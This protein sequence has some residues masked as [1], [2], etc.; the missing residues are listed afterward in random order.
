MSHF[1]VL[2]VSS[3]KLDQNV[4]HGLLAP[5]HEFECTGHDDEY[6]QDIDQTEE[7]RTEYETGTERRYQDPEG[8]LHDPYEDRFYRDPTSE[9]AE[10][11]GIGGTGFSNGL[12][13][14]SKN[15]GD[16]KGYRAKVHFIPDDWSE[17]KIPRPQVETFAKF[18][19]DNY[20]RKV[21]A[22][23]EEPDL[24]DE[25]KY[26]YA[27]LD[28][29]G[30][31]VKVINRTN[32][33][34]EWDWWVVGGRWSGFFKLKNITESL[35]RGKLGQPSAFG[36][37]RDDLDGRAD[38]CQIRDIDLDGMRSEAA[39]TALEEFD[40]AHAVIAG[41]ELPDFEALRAEC[42]DD[43]E[44]FREKFW[45]HPV[46]VELNAIKPFWNADEVTGLRRTREQV[47]AEARAG[48][49]STFAVLKDGKWHERGS[50][51]WFGMVSDEKDYGKWAS[52][53]N[54][55]LDNSPPETWVAVVDCHI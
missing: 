21:V 12:S 20:G 13:F 43:H 47:E 9:E 18:L 48:A 55:M 33:N 24:S 52:E 19:D 53:F 29:Q 16:G 50:M 34:A 2:V 15:W 7:V 1:T 10:K 46:L 40:K 36:P 35:S 44:M 54:A 41:R 5:F 25:H 45:K 28:E 37:N 39:Q 6:V 17:V 14:T 51:G 4:L 23:G 49:I 11:I 3:D 42:G 22:A 38:I 8:G 27:V 26:G 31:V 32:P 30:E